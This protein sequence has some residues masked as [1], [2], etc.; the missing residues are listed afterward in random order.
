MKRSEAAKRIVCVSFCRLNQRLSATIVEAPEKVAPL[1]LETDCFVL[2]ANLV[3]QQEDW[4]APELL[5]LYKNQVGIVNNFSF[6]KD[7]V[8]VNCIFL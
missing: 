4:S 5:T 6:L 7:P 3:Y 2:L 8:I 1:R